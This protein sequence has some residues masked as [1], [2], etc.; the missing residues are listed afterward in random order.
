MRFFIRVL[1]SN[2]LNIGY[3]TNSNKTIHIIKTLEGKVN[4]NKIKKYKEQ[5][6]EKFTPNRFNQTI[7]K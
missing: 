6:I 5:I 1:D 4:W 2:H 3:T 7:F